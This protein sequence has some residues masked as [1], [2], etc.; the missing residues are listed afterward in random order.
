MTST[1]YN[2]ILGTDTADDIAGTSGADSISALQAD[3][4]INGLGGADLIFG[5]KGNDSLVQGTT[6]NETVINGNE[7]NDTLNLSDKAS[8]ATLYG[9]KGND[10]LLF[11]DATFTNAYAS[12]DQ[13]ADSFKFAAI[14]GSTINGDGISGTNQGNDRITFTSISNGVILADKG[15]DIISFDGLAYDATIYGGKGNDLIQDPGSSL[16]NTLIR[17]DLGKDTIDFGGTAL[18]LNSTILGD[19]G[20]SEGGADSIVATN[21]GIISSVS[22]SG[23]AGNDT[24]QFFSGEIISSN[25]NANAGND[26][27]SAAGTL[28]AT[29]LYGGQGNDEVLLAGPTGTGI[30]GGTVSLDK[31]NDTVS[32]VATK[33]TLLGGEGNDTLGGGF[34]SVR[35]EGNKG[36]DFLGS[37]AAN[38]V[39]MYGGQ[40]NDTFG[41]NANGVSGQVGLMKL[42]SGKIYLDKGNDL[43]SGAAGVSGSVISGGEGK[44]TISIGVDTA[45]KVSILGGDGAD[46]INYDL[47]GLSVSSGG[48]MGTYFY[49]FG[50]GND[51]INFNTLASSA[52]VGNITF[53]IDER[54]NGTGTFSIT[55]DTASGTGTQATLVLGN[56]TITFEGNS[57]NSFVS[58]ATGGGINIT[59][60]TVSS[61]TITDLG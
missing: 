60:T 44:D 3:D 40:G 2:S 61:S 49:G 38:K 42:T 27:I 56:N 13:G 47:Q 37:A 12:G 6:A 21:S 1:V 50:G 5:G 41:E 19:N 54:F 46:S 20:S 36:N 43:F 34:T 9:G 7:G 31:G 10:T 16:S 8:G 23:G 33:A 35:V 26:L 17:G 39:T 24:I 55:A 58:T 52:S 14:Y 48:S 30:E 45:G 59:L 4:F 15:D 11:D 18:F 32:G 57:N 22:L 25:F 51:T 53:A 29:T 28:V